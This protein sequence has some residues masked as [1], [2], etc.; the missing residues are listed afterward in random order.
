MK[1]SSNPTK[2]ENAVIIK[3][4][5]QALTPKNGLEGLTFDD[6]MI[7]P[8]KIRVHPDEVDL[9]GRFTRNLPLHLPVV[10]APMSTVF[11]PQLA[12]VM[13]A[14][15]ACSPLPR[16]MSTSN[17]RSIAGELKKSNP[18]CDVVATCSPFDVQKVR[19][20]LEMEF[21][22]SVILDTVAGHN[23]TVY[24]TLKPFSEKQLSRICVGNIATQEAAEEL[25]QYPV[26]AIKVGF[27]PGSICTT[28]RETGVGMPQLQAVHEVSSV[29][30]CFDIPVI[31][32]GGIRSNGDIAKAL[33]AGA[34][35]VMMGRLFAQTQEA[36]GKSTVVEGSVHKE[37]EGAKYSTIELT[38]ELLGKES[39]VGQHRSEGVSGSV[40]QVGSAKLL[41][42]TIERALKASF[43]FVGASSL[44]DFHKLAAFVQ[45]SSAAIGQAGHHGI[46]HL[47]KRNLIS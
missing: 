3:T 9:G 21:I 30:S 6:V 5:H 1:K 10:A 35:S 33:A 45:V 24:S 27:G 43:A 23:E 38:E 29:A 47:T 44:A 14:L 17:V 2:K 15:G 42:L 37:Y 22:D 26:G 11:S 28:T 12:L 36:G 25:C 20:L 7:R 46:E 31:A 39:I 13:H 41:L 18:S 16:E 4:S 40:P 8:G 34:S 19:S 32:D